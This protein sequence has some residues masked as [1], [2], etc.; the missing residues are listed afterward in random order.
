MRQFRTKPLTRFF[1]GLTALL[2]LF[3]VLAYLQPPDSRGT[4][5]RNVK[6]GVDATGYFYTEVETYHA[7]EE[8]LRNG[9]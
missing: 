4:L 6:E 9:R 8:G 1:A 7:L 5:H 3:A 2:L